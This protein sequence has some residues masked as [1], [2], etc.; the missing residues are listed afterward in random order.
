MVHFSPLLEKKTS[1]ELN[2]TWRDTSISTLLGGV[3]QFSEVV[4]S[5]KEFLRRN[6]IRKSGHSG[7]IWER[8]VG[9]N[10]SV[11]T[12]IQLMLR[13]SLLRR[14][15]KEF[16]KCKVSFPKMTSCHLL[17]AWILKGRFILKKAARW[18]GLL[19][20]FSLWS[21]LVRNLP[22]K[23]SFFPL[24]FTKIPAR[25][26]SFHSG[27]L[28]LDR[29]RR[30]S[31]TWCEKEWWKTK[32][33]REIGKGKKFSAFEWQR[34]KFSLTGSEKREHKNFVKKVSSQLAN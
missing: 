22:L 20:R 4:Y 33:K 18:G 10:I 15:F 28:S 8:K 29:R 1:R 6:P 7:N 16:R 14:E 23:A 11:L 13:I 17:L 9:E 21:L 25:S 34:S 30:K 32:Q 2:A 3:K 26:F 19:S 24:F 31:E 12:T 27:H 5:Y